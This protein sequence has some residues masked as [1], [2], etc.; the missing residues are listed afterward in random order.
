MLFLTQTFTKENILQLVMKDC[1]G[2]QVLQV[3]LV[4][5]SLVK[6]RLGYLLMAGT[7]FKLKNKQNRHLK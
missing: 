7:E 2:L 1:L 6:K 5:V 4:F 3:Q